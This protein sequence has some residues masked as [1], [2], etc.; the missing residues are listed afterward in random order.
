MMASMGHVH[1]VIASLLLAQAAG[2]SGLIADRTL[3][4][5]PPGIP[6]GTSQK[7]VALGEHGL[8]ARVDLSPADV[9]TVQVGNRSSDLVSFGPLMFPLIPMPGLFCLLC[10]PTEDGHRLFVRVESRAGLSWDPSRLQLRVDDGPW[11]APR[12]VKWAGGAVTRP[13][14]MALGGG[15]SDFT[16]DYAAPWSHGERLSVMIDGIDTADGP[17]TASEL[18]FEPVTCWFLGF[19]P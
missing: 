18:R 3:A 16:L 1:A 15:R 7:S 6:E 17:Y 2:C 10:T 13:E 19:Y 8:I 9:V 11:T 12:S 14:P 4:P 5:V